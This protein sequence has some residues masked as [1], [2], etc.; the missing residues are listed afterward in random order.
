[1]VAV[2]PLENRGAKLTAEELR[3]LVD[4]L[5][6]RLGEGGRFLVIPREEMKKRLVEQKQDSYRTCFDQSCQIEIGRELAAQFTVATSISRLGERCVV[7][8]GLYDLGKAATTRSGTAKVGCAPED[9]LT[10]IDEVADKLRGTAAPPREPPPGPEVPGGHGGRFVQLETEPQGAEVLLDDK[11]VGVTPMHV[12]ADRGRDYRLTLRKRGYEH[13]E[14]AITDITPPKLTHAL[15]RTPEGIREGEIGRN[16]WFGVDLKGGLSGDKGTMGAK[17]RIV[18][19]KW[20][21]VVWTV[22]EVAAILE[23]FDTART[24]GFAGSRVAYPLYLGAEGRHQLRFGLAP[25][26]CF[27]DTSDAVEGGSTTSTKGFCLSPSVT[28]V[29]QTG[30]WFHIGAGVWT[31]IPLVEDG[32]DK[33][34]L[35]FMLSLPMGWTGESR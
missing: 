25:G 34:P 21:H 32:P 14:V 20:E 3:S 2:F 12:R 28:Y 8:A 29:Y 35:T 27:I 16:E 19:L 10:A 5:A 33:I 22:A 23:G 24:Y 30:G 11:L 9:L 18:V 4:Y 1:V 6:T 7:T 13:F 31:M 26:F 15:K 17:F